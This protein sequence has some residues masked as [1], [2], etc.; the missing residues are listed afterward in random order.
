MRTICVF[1]SLLFLLAGCSENSVSKRILGSWEMIP[2]KDMQM[3]E[4]VRSGLGLSNRRIII[5]F[6]EDGSII[7]QS[8]Q[9]NETQTREGTYE[10]AEDGKTFTIYREGDRTKKNISGIANVSDSALT[11][12]DISGSGDTMH[13][14]KIEWNINSGTE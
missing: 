6:K 12:I 4:E 10:M 2:S 1:I 9:N 13:L 8:V 7:N 14:K 11:L 3:T 5:T